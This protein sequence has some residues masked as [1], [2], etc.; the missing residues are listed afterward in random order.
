MSRVECPR[1]QDVLDALA[2]RRWPSRGDPALAVHVAECGICA[3]L[4]TVARA[5][6]D[7]DALPEEPARDLPPPS[8]VWWRAQ[9]RARE[10]A[11]RAAARPLRAVQGAAL[12]C[13]ALLAL[14]LLA[15]S[16][17][18]LSNWF[19]PIAARATARLPDVDAQ[20][21]SQAAFAAFASPGVQLAAAAWLVLGPLAVYLAFAR[22]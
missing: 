10:E 17:P 12:V 20:A 3:D 13:G 21:L 7:G 2:S 18:Y 9:L 11:A 1:E 15:G 14:V 4:V 5:F 6:L 19:G 16:G 22:D 8:L